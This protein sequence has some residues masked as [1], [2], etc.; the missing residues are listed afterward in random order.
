MA[1]EFV[2]MGSSIGSFQHYYMHTKAMV[3]Y[4]K[5]ELDLR[6]YK[7]IVIYLLTL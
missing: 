1:P 4:C 6:F 3:E 2:I 7:Q 5:N